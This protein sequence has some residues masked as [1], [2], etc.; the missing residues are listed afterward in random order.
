M[1]CDTPVP[2]SEIVSGEFVALLDT[3]TVPAELPADA[4]VNVALNVAVCPGV[5]IVPVGTPL[6][7]KPAPEMLTL[8][9][10]TLELPALVN[11]T[12]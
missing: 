4:G 7:V 5:K 8:E 1:T 2:E 3:V 10:V 11:V 12:F 6:A 9:T